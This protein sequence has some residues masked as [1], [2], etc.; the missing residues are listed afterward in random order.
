MD[1]RLYQEALRRREQIQKQLGE[2]SAELDA[3][4]HV[5]RVY[6]G[7]LIKDVDTDYKDSAEVPTQRDEGNSP[8]ARRRNPLPPRT[9]A[10]L[11]RAEIIARKRPMTRGELVDALEAK[12]VSLHAQDKAK[13]LGTILWRFREEFENIPG[14]GYWP[15]D[16]PLDGR[17]L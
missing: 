4:E 14:R 7:S 6:R 2:L 15:K 13:N 11:A 3:I 16:V 17:L 5:I 9:L 1:E 10:D 8:G 12:G